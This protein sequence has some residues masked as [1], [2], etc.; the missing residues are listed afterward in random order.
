MNQ[1]TKN[2]KQLQKKDKL[3]LNDRNSRANGIWLLQCMIVLLIGID[4]L[5]GGLE[6]FLMT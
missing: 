5:L 6:S 3:S 4:P 2:A 1:N